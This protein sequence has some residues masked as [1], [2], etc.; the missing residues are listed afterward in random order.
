M[1]N[2]K[3]AYFAEIFSVEQYRIERWLRPKS[4]SVIFDPER[5]IV[6]GADAADLRL[7]GITGGIGPRY[8]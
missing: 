3:K 4:G 8:E 1:Q 2:T 7:G 6:A 5:P